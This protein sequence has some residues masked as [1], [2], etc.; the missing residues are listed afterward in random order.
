[1]IATV[2]VPMLI[3]PF[4]G[5]AVIIGANATYEELGMVRQVPTAWMFLVAAGIAV[6]VV[7]AWVWLRSLPAESD[8]AHAPDAAPEPHAV[9]A[10]DADHPDT[11][12]TP[13]RRETPEPTE[14]TA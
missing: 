11:P 7:I 9:H 4:I 3:G 2:L 10:T 5:A 6:L 14:P 12:A 8:A 13:E 1:M